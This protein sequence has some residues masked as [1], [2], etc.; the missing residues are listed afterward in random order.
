MVLHEMGETVDSD[1]VVLELKQKLLLC[2]M[3]LED[4]EFVCDVL[5]TMIEDRMEKEEHRKKAE[6][7]RLEQK[8][9]LELVRI[10]AR[11]KTEN[12][13]RIREARHKEEMEEAR[14]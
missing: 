5:A 2:K 13:T 11:W 10:E 7:C 1:L 8:Q 3:Y 14:L 12:E 9:E 4:E 6:E